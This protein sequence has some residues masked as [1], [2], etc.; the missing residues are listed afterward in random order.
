MFKLMI[1]IKRKRGMAMEDFIE[2]YETKHAPL[3]RSKVPNLKRYV[4]HFL[5]PYGNEMYGADA[6]LPYDVVTEIWFDDR[7][8][9]ERGM[10]YLSEPETAKII[11][12]DEEKLFERSSI[13]FVIVEDHETDLRSG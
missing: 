6:E 3:G 11:A 8:D 7:A 9:F 4:R 5:R 10:A 1:L 12:A 2:Y 13:R